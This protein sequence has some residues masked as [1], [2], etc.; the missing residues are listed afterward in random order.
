MCGVSAINKKRYIANKRPYIEMTKLSY[1]DGKIKYYH[2]LSTGFRTS[3]VWYGYLHRTA[4]NISEI[5]L[6]N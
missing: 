5:I 1:T 6:V 4:E 2:N 3:E